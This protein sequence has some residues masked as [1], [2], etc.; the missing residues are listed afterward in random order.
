MY[1]LLFFLPGT[2]AE[3]YAEAA[4]GGIISRLVVTALRGDYG[5]SQG[6]E[7]R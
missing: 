7:E 6:G 5:L 1:L 2:G 3:T 4:F